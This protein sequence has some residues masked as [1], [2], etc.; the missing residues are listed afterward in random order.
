MSGQGPWAECDRCGFRV[1]HHSCSTEWTGIFVCG[2]CRDPRPPWLDPPFIDPLE[3][4][5]L[6]NA[7]FKKD[8]V[9]TDDD[10]PVTGDDL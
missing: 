2:K 8:E 10:N 1:R 7:R 5:P 9:F 6:P 3:G 4:M